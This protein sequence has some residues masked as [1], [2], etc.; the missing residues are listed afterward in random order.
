MAPEAQKTEIQKFQKYLKAEMPKVFIEIE[1]Y[2]KALKAGTL[3]KTT[4]TPPQFTL[5]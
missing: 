3:K 5:E 1:V 2:E 4:K